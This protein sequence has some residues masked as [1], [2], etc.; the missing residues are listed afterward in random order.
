MT[1]YILTSIFILLAGMAEGG[2]DF[3]QFHYLGSNPFW[4]PD[5]SW[6]NKYRNRDPSQGQ[7]FIG[8]YFVAFTDGWHMLKM[9]QHFFL[10]SSFPL[11]SIAIHNTYSIYHWWTF[12]LVA[13]GLLVLRGI[14]FTIVY[15]LFK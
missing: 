7:S 5:I 9:V 1:Y 12:V 6:K 10:F 14:G 8:R 11:L 4:Q 13:L 2:M 3:L 15:S